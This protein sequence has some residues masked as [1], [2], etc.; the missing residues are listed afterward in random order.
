VKVANN[1]SDTLEVP[2]TAKFIK[3]NGRLYQAEAFKKSLPVFLL[4][5]AWVAVIEIL[6]T[7]DYGKLPAT[8]V[9]QICQGIDQQIPKQ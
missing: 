8:T 2:T 9:T 1:Q 7:R 6:N 4:P 3:I 5:E